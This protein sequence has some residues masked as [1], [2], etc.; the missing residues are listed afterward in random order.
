MMLEIWNQL[1]VF[2]IFLSN[3]SR[4]K[5]NNKIILLLISSPKRY[6]IG[7]DWVKY[8]HSLH[9][10]LV[11]VNFSCRATAHVGLLDYG[12]PKPGETV[13]VNG[14]AGAIGSTA[15]QIAKIQVRLELLKYN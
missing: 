5:K 3:L 12:E 11:L 15:G 13:L 6:D 4:G 14:A 7:Q 8:A 10:I 9:T 1:N 2:E